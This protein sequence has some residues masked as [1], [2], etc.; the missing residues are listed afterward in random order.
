[1]YSFSMVHAGLGRSLGRS[2][3]VDLSDDWDEPDNLRKVG[4]AKPQPGHP[5]LVMLGPMSGLEFRNVVQKCTPDLFIPNKVGPNDPRVSWRQ[6][7][8]LW[9][10]PPSFGV[11]PTEAPA[12]G[13]ALD[14]TTRQEWNSGVVGDAGTYQDADDVGWILEVLHQVRSRLQ[15]RIDDRI[16]AGILDPGVEVFDPERI[17][18]VGWSSGGSMAY[19]LAFEAPLFH[20]DSPTY[21][22]RFAAMFAFGG[23][24]GGFR[25]GRAQSRGLMRVDFSPSSAGNAPATVERSY[26][27][28]TGQTTT[29]PNIR[30]MH[31][32]GA[33]DDHLP[34]QIFGYAPRRP[35]SV[36]RFQFLGAFL[37]DDP[38]R[39]DGAGQE[40]LVCVSN[41]TVA[42]AVAVTGQAVAEAMVTNARWDYPVEYGLE[43]WIVYKGLAAWS[44]RPIVSPLG[45]A[46]GTLQGASWFS[47]LWPGSPPNEVREYGSDGGP[48]QRL[49]Y[50]L[51][52]ASGD[53]EVAYLNVLGLED[54]WDDSPVNLGKMAL[55]FFDGTFP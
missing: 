15:A 25:R 33:Q 16:A 28:G 44:D 21:P 55:D 17:Y 10:D 3:W 39:D 7:I 4:M 52:S 32:Q 40:A 22:Y 23:S 9:P 34:N 31:V 24:V 35:L 29:N 49:L 50:A 6:A 18:L 51:P 46:T 1:L 53:V 38:F 19:R 45:G 27:T 8:V 30:I 20:P 13:L 12:D 42:R 14:R 43:R 48:Y 41:A 37:D 47:L 26:G 2:T 11:K 36:V 54:D 5:V